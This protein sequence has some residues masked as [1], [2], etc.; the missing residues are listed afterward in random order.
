MLRVWPSDKTLDSDGWGAILVAGYDVTGREMFSKDVQQFGDVITSTVLPTMCISKS[1]CEYIDFNSPTTIPV[2]FRIESAF[3]KLNA[4]GIHT[5][6]FIYSGHHDTETGFL[7]GKNE[8]FPTNKINECI[9]N[10]RGV[11]TV[12]AFLD[13]CQAKTIDVKDICLIQF[14]ATGP[15]A[16]A[17]GLRD[18]GS[19][20]TKY[21]LQ[22]FTLKASGAQC[23]QCGSK[24]K[25]DGDFI[26]LGN[27]WTYIGN[28]R[29]GL[30]SMEPH[31][32]TKNIEWRT[33][34]LAYNYASK[35]EF[36]FEVS[37][38]ESF[39][40]SINILASGLK[41]FEALKSQ[42]LFPVL[43]DLLT[44]KFQCKPKEPITLLSK[45]ANILSIEVDFASRNTDDID[46]MEK[47]VMAWNSKRL[48]R[49]KPRLC[50]RIDNGKPV[51]L[52]LKQGKL[53][54]KMVSEI[55]YTT[56]AYTFPELVRLV[57]FLEEEED[58]LQNQELLDSSLGE[59]IDAIS[60]ITKKASEKLTEKRIHINFIDFFVDKSVCLV[61]LEL[62]D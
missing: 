42:Q 41:D 44:E 28:H 4:K 32:N 14:N 58:A 56:N 57:Q 43:V 27:L 61:H 60:N 23:S 10:M 35:V 15:N 9:Q 19:Y 18:E 7:I 20:F 2:A 16:V 48:L 17:I 3:E 37:I 12:I 22:A 24:C 51:G 29:S 54:A 33:T 11:K 21:L 53:V 38:D 8:Y 47:L 1:L 45:Y 46:T 50:T 62:Q 6:V 40:K 36:P 13:C 26:T 55:G 49:C 31:L 25:L 52:F 59:F 30:K 34:Y 39:S 5:L